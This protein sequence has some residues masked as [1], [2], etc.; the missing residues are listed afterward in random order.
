MS[1]CYVD[2]N[3]ETLQHL[4][5]QCPSA[6]FTVKEM[7]DLFFKN[8]ALEIPRKFREKDICQAVN[9]HFKW[10]LWN[11]R[12]DVKYNGIKWENML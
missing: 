3:N 9:I 5:F 10:E 8:S 12:N 2:N 11:I 1:S 7:E 4:L 6:K